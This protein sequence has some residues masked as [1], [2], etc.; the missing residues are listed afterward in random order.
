ML[1]R[2][3]ITAFLM[4]EILELEAQEYFWDRYY[5]MMCLLWFYIDY[6]GIYKVDKQT[7]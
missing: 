3:A 4:R 7:K 2:L 1:R 5:F 6:G